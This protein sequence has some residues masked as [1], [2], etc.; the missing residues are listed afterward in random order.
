[1]RAATKARPE[2]GPG[3]IRLGDRVRLPSGRLAAVRGR[4]GRALCL[5][6]LDAPD[7]ELRILPQHVRPA[8]A[9]S[10]RKRK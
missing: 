9:A 2:T 7:E 4:W 10:M 8:P 3:P 5:F 1:M 6:Y